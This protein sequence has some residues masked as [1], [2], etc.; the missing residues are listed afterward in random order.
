MPYSPLVT[1][2]TRRRARGVTLA[3]IMVSTSILLAAGARAQEADRLSGAF[4]LAALGGD[5]VENSVTLALPAGGGTIAGQMAFRIEN[6]PFAFGVDFLDEDEIE[7]PDCTLTL[8]LAGTVVAGEYTP[9]SSALAGELDAEVFLGDPQNCDP[10]NPP[11]VGEQTAA[12]PWVA[13]YDPSLGVLAGELDLLGNSP[14]TFTAAI[15][16]DEVATTSTT[17]ATTT[18]EGESGDE[19]DGEEEEEEDGHYFA[20]VG[21][22]PEDAEFRVLPD[23]DWQLITASTRIP[24]GAEIFVG[25]DP[26]VLRYDE[27]DTNVVI[28]PFSQVG[29]SFL[30]AEGSGIAATMQLRLGRVAAQVNPDKTS[31]TDFSV[32]A[33]IATASVRGTIFAVTWDGERMEVEVEEGTVEVASDAGEERDIHGGESV[34]VSDAGFGETTAFSGSIFGSERSVPVLLVAGLSALALALFALG[35]RSQR[36]AAAAAR[37]APPA[38]PPPSPV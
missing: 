26:L 33:P 37:S 23:Q 1:E 29:T 9:G 6:M 34:T 18:S 35:I 27:W 24:T 36:R 14:L 32:K 3:F 16:D 22:V 15:V 13:T 10:D 20:V 5:V 31:V 8:A 28:D 30:A 11:N 19:D 25:G 2:V 4:D 17:E 7:F 21:T 12:F 38:P